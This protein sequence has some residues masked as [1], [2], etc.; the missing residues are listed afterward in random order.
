MRLGQ[1]RRVPRQGRIASRE[2]RHCAP[3]LPV[4]TRLAREA[5]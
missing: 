2:K 5:M 4:G 3:T 1:I